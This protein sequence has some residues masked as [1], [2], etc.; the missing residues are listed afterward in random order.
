MQLSL[1]IPSCNEASNLPI[2]LNALTLAL[3]KSRLKYEIIVVDDASTDNTTKVLTPYLK[4]KEIIVV[5]NEARLGKSLSVLAGYAKSKGSYSALIDAD[6][7]SCAEAVV[8]LYEAAQSGYAVTTPSRRWWNIIPQKSGKKGPKVFPRHTFDHLDNSSLT[9]WNIEQELVHT[10]SNLGLKKGTVVC[11]AVHRTRK[12]PFSTRIKRWVSTLRSKVVHNTT[13]PV[14]VHTPTGESSMVGAGITYRKQ[15]FITHTTIPHGISALKTFA[16]WQVLLILCVIGST[17]WGLVV[18]PIPT[19]IVLVAILSCIYL[20]DVIFNFYVTLKSLHFPPEIAFSELELSAIDDKKLPLYTILCPL[21]KEARVLPHFVSSMDRLDYPVKKLDIMLLLEEDDTETIETAR[22]M[23]LPSHYRIIIVPKSSPK[24]KPKACNYGLAHARGEYVVIYDAEDRPEPQ[25]LKKAYLALTTTK[26][27]SGCVQAKLNYFNYSDNLLTRFFTAEYSLWFDVILPGLQSINTTIPLGG[28]SN[29]FKTSVLRELQGWD[30]FNVTEDADLGTRLFNA[31]YQTSIIDS[32]TLEEANSNWHNWMRQRSRWLKGYMQ[33]YLVH[34]RHPLTLFRKLGVHALLFNLIIGGK[35][36]FILINPFLWAMTISYFTLY[37]YLGAFIESIYPATIFYIA[38]TSLLFGNFIALYNYMIGCAKRGHWELVKYV[39]L[40]PLYWLAIS[41]A[42]GIALIQLITK[43]H[44]WEKTIHGLDLV[45]ASLAEDKKTKAQQSSRKRARYIQ[46]FID[47]G[48]NLFHAGGVMVL[49]N[50]FANFMNFLYN[51]YLSRRVDLAAFGDIALFGSFLYLSS[52]PISG[53]SRT[54][55]HTTGY[56]VGKYNRVVTA[57]WSKYQHN[58]LV[59]GVMASFTWLIISPAIKSFFQINSMVPLLIFAPIWLIRIVGSG[60]SGYLSG[61]MVFGIMALSAITESVVK[62]GSTVFLVGINQDHL[63]YV[64]VLL[65]LMVSVTLEWIYIKRA[66][67]KEDSTISNNDLKLSKKFYIT[68]VVTILTG[69]TYLTLDV[70]LAKHFLSPVEAG[71]YG[72]LS[73]A[74][75]MVFFLGGMFSQFL[76]PYVSRDIGAGGSGR[77]SFLRIV[78]LVGLA[79]LGAVVAFGFLGYYTAPLLWGS[80]AELIIPHLPLYSVAMALFS[81]SSLIITFQQ[82]H[83]RYLFPVAGFGLSLLQIIGMLLVHDSIT[84]LVYVVSISSFITLITLC[85]MTRFYGAI[86]DS[87]HALVDLYGLFRAL[88]EPKAVE[89]G[90]LRIL[91]FNWRDLRHKWA[92]GAEV[93]IHELA[94]RWVSGGHKVTVFAGSDGASKRF[95]TIDGVHI[96]RRGG[97]YLVYIWAFLYYTLLLR[98]RYDVIIDSENGL[99]FFTPLY[100]RVPTFLL[101]HHVHQEVFRTSLVPPFAQI[102]AF[103]EKRIM[104]VIYRKTEVITVSPSSKTE[105]L[106]HK[107]TRRTPHIVYNGIELTKFKPGKKATNPTVL[108]LGRL[109]TAKSVH[110]L[111]QAIAKLKHE[112][113]N[114]ECVIAGDGP[115]RS[116]LEKIVKN[117]KLEATVRFVGRVSE[118]EKIAL[119]QSAWVFVNPSLLEGWGITTI[120][121]NACGTPVVASDVPGLRDAVSDTHSGILVPYGRVD[122]FVVAIDTIL[123]K[124][125]LRARMS[126]EARA[127]G[128]QYDWNK[129]AKVALEIM[130]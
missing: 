129:S 96:I 6:M 84:S 14:Y 86:V 44:Y 93:Y 78:G 75:K 48:T 24:T 17:G 51:A 43:P 102:A 7:A 63:V 18:A 30:A 41:Y 4:K 124:N 128:L 64:A 108:Y 66:P 20:I 5:K 110:I 82:L 113:Q 89:N 97:F 53:M 90:K 70:M 23:D 92:G 74:G 28:T 100:A 40:I 1:I 115:M 122:C 13:S 88:P 37:A 55:T 49:A 9:D 91:I 34:M 32:T 25:Q 2:I 73:L 119:Y 35:I 19:L 29:H 127:W 58:L 47:R 21:Y 12:K 101:I 125:S 46:T 76:I 62:F 68:S 27:K 104:P 39:Y 57:V 79:N 109:T 85:L 36:A 8:P 61:N 117:T 87:W 130:T 42:A 11:N 123:K 120:E 107:L 33:T 105:I 45:K 121:A 114:L 10:A 56:L 116:K 80:N 22:S 83:K 38:V 16:P 77:K 65:A 106:T 15:N 26:L 118:S 111:I 69:I 72:Y 50:V 94:K 67:N 60:N 81:M 98:G 31:G 103:L 126:K 99:P 112:Y 3:S 54:L 95:E 52:I 59:Y 71:A